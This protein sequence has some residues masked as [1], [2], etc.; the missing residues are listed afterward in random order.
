MALDTWDPRAAAPGS[1]IGFPALTT[2]YPQPPSPPNPVAYTD[3]VT[4][5]VPTLA[6][7]APNTMAAASATPVTLTLTGTLFTVATHVS[8]AGIEDHARIRR[9]VYI[10]PTQLKVDLDPVGLAA[11][12]YPVLV[13]SADE[14]VSTPAV[15]FTIT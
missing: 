4:R 7:I 12:A 8:F 6:S 3:P 13:I 9:V 2:P 11:A 14:Q 1:P 5:P 10:S 15:N